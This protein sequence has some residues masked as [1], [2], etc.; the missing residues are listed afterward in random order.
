MS[1]RDVR[2]RIDLGILRSRGGYRDRPAGDTVVDESCGKLSWVGTPWG[3]SDDGESCRWATR[4]RWER[5]RVVGGPLGSAERPGVRW[6]HVGACGL[7]WHWHW[8]SACGVL[9]V[10][11][12]SGPTLEDG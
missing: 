12:R 8:Q 3:K 7:H 1:E 11:L 6:L 4:W 9:T 2:T 5:R 10:E